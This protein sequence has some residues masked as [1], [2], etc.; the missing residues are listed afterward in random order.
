MLKLRLNSTGASA[1]KYLLLLRLSWSLAMPGVGV[2]C[3]VAPYRLH[4]R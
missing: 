3:C 1:W 4:C 2:P